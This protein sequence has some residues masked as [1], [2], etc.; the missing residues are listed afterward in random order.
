M[1][2]LAFEALKIQRVNFITPKL[3]AP[4]INLGQISCDSPGRLR[5]ISIGG[6]IRGFLWI[7]QFYGWDSIRIF[8]IVCDSIFASVLIKN[9]IRIGTHILCVRIYLTFYY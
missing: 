9:Y 6:R 3:G 7:G 4:C 8:T 1:K 2:Q 5:G